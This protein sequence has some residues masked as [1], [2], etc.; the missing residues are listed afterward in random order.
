[1]AA[2]KIKKID[3]KA[4]AGYDVSFLAIVLVLVSFGLIMLFSASHAYTLYRFDNSFY[5]ISK[6]SIFAVVGIVCMFFISKIDYHI[7]R[8]FAYVILGVAIVLLVIVLFMKPLNGA[9]RWIIIP[10]VGTFQPSEI[11][12]FAIVIIFSH[13]ACTNFSKMKTFKYGVLPFAIV[14][15]T[16]CVLMLLEPHLSGTILILLIGI[17][18]MI[19]GGTGFKWFALGGGLCTAGLIYVVMFT[20]VISYA[21][22]RIQLWRDPWLDPIDKGFQTIQSLLSIGSGG[23][24]GL[25][26]GQSRQKYMYIPEPHNDFIFSVICEELGFIGA[27]VVIL[28]FVALMWRGFAIAMKAKDK[29]G[30]MIVIGLTVQVGLQ[31]LL[32]IAVVTNTVPNTGISLPFFSYGGTSLMML[33]AQMGIILSVSRYS[34]RD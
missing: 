30:A 21:S 10:Y 33:L 26:L 20:N 5:F 34:N 4:A 2:K 7:Y 22:S 23:L 12:K 15:G 6:Q 31:A 24:F 29:F 14:M 19:V 13:I 11:A 8:K 17:V 3:K 32:N 1:M 25:G 27:V 28:L 16:M 9:R 18:L